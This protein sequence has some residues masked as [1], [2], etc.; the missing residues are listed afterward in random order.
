[1][2]ALASL[3]HPVLHLKT[4]TAIAS[5]APLKFTSGTL[6]TTAEARAVEFLTDAYYGTITTGATEKT[7]LS[8][9]KV[10]FYLTS[11]TLGV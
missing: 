6:L 9:K 5:T 11:P 1:M 4:G 3:P 10:Q 7:L 8:W 2:W